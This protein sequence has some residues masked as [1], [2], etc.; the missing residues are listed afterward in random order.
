MVLFGERANDAAGIAVCQHTGGNV[1]GDNAS[2]TDD[3]AASDG[4]T[5]KNRDITAEPNVI[6]QR[7]WLCALQ[8]LI[9]LVRKHGMNGGIHAAVWANET[10]RTDG[11]GRAVHQ[12]CAV[13]E[14]RT[15]S[16]RAVIPVIG[17][18]WRENH[19]GLSEFR[20][21]RAENLLLFLCLI[22][23]RVVELKAQHICVFALL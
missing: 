15:L 18:K 6:A 7:D 12:I 11:D 19:D 16:N 13:I 20:H 9:A 4:H 22:G 21:Q 8:S 23:R 17:I 10:V 1:F 14:K 5:G 2:G 3:A